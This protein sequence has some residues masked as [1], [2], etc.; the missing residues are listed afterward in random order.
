MNSR[1]VEFQRSLDLALPRGQSAFLWGPRKT[2]KTT[3]LKQRFP[4]SRRYDLLETDL[5]FSLAK[6]PR[7]LREELLLLGKD[8]LN[9]PVIIDEV[10]KIPALLDEVHWLIENKGISF[11]LCGSSA[12]KLKR[13]AA[14][15]L[16]G[17]AWRYQL[18]PL[19]TREIPGFDLLRALNTG[20]V[21]SHYLS[22]DPRRSLHAYV[23]DYL[24][25]EI[26]AEGLARNVPAFSRFLDSLAFSNGELTNYSNISR[27]CGVDAK[28]VKEY[29]QILVDTM[30]GYIVEPFSKRAGREVITAASKFYCFDAG[31]PNALAGEGISQL[32]GDRA[33]RLFENF[34]LTEL[35]AYRSYAAL[36]FPIRF[37]RT[38]T[39]LEVDFILG[40]SVAVEIKLTERVDKTELRGL[41]AFVEEHPGYR[42]V[43]V[44]REP[45]ARRV[46]IKHGKTVD[47]LPWKQFLDEL[48]G[49]KIIA[50]RR[51]PNP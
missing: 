38:K 4:Q 35:M 5:L 20:L 8:E 12:R 3:F 48:W 30:L 46:A 44:S 21:P 43:L 31:I 17:R 47:I 40:E 36:E 15:L 10:Q 24:Q 32:K 7:R 50:G 26:R 29:Y 25:E 23:L 19:T 9:R 6:E 37:W 1:L 41:A 11:I 34:I 33:G 16:G 2:G 39:G 49:G 18:F 13:G 42:A 22:A 14:N 51:G 27:D 45:R 28:T